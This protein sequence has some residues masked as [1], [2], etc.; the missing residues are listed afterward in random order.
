MRT[1]AI[2]LLAAA[3]CLPA[4]ARAQKSDPFIRLVEFQIW[5]DWRGPEVPRLLSN[6]YNEKG[7]SHNF[8]LQPRYELF[9]WDEGRVRGWVD[10]AIKLGCFNLFSIGDDT[11]VSEGYLFTT[12]GLNPSF[13]DFYFNSVAYAH[14]HGLM[15]AVEPRAL[16][17]PVTR[18]NVR[19]WAVSFLDPSLGRDKVTDIV[20][21]SIEWFDAYKHNPNI[22]EETEA[23]I[24]GVRSVNPGVLVYL[25]SIGGRWRQVRQFHNW[26][27]GRYPEMIISHYL[28]ADQVEAFRAAGAANM[29]VQINPQEFQPDDGQFFVF[30]DRTVKI[31]KE[32]VAKKVP[33]LSISGVNYGYSHYNYD[34]FLDILRPHL[35]LVR[36]VPELRAVLG[37]NR[38]VNKA[39]PADV[40]AEELETQRKRAR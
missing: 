6:L 36:T 23:F 27:M 20:K 17:K 11:R 10:E 35:N 25:D 4:P 40:R 29:M 32:V 33:L 37:K 28:N 3:S 22:A 38:P 2:I 9:L 39:A 31:L 13:R 12:E 24:E 18:E 16:P 7:R 19:K 5:A 8:Q 34:L 30:H 26:I 14:K 21:M 15:A 1:R